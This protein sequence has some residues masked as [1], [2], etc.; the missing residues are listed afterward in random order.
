MCRRWIRSILGILSQAMNYYVASIL[1]LQYGS[2]TASIVVWV[3]EL[4]MAEI[5]DCKITQTFR[6]CITYKL[7]FKNRKALKI[8]ALAYSTV[9]CNF[10]WIMFR[11]CFPRASGMKLGG[12]SNSVLLVAFHNVSLFSFRPGV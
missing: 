10:C 4:S 6:Y 8:M 7:L 9:N 5:L 12:K 11:G 3:S 1:A 2:N